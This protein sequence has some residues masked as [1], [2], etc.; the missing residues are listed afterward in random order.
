M[1]LPMPGMASTCLGSSINVG[2]LLRVILD[3]LRGVAVGADA[4][5]I[6]PVDFEQVGGFV[7]NVGDGLVVHGQVRLNKLDGRTRGGS[8]STVQWWRRS[9]EINRTGGRS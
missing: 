9:L 8:G 4:E 3:G 7:E 1:P 6:L 5:G 2:D